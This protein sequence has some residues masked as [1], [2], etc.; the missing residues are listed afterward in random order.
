LDEFAGKPVRAFVVWEPVLA[1]DWAAPSSFVL[2]RIRDPR[3]TQ[4]WDK[5]R[6]VS[7]AMGEHDR[8]SIVWDRV[9]VYAPDVLWNR[10][11]PSPVFADG[12]VIRIIDRTRAALRKYFNSEV[13]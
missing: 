5:E 13:R 10:V 11:P 3:A 12:P 9:L 8:K 7:L 4:F 6:L 1:T 2:K